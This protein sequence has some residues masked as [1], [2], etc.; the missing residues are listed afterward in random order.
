MIFVSFT[1]AAQ[2]TNSSQQNSEESYIYNLAIK[3][4]NLQHDYDFLYCDYLLTKIKLDL[5]NLS[6]ELT[7]KANSILISNYHKNMDIGLYAIYRNYYN[8][9]LDSFEQTKEQANSIKKIIT[10]KIE[11][12][13]FSDIET[14]A[15]RNDC[16]LIDK[17]IISVQ[18]SFNYYSN[19]LDFYND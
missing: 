19:V 17:Y 12:S 14:R 16:Q 6:N 15:L 9:M 13:N 18:D 11:N 4:E 3:L 8:S 2:N 10:L 5:T 1:A 7:I